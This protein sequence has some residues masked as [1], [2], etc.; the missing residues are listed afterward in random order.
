MQEKSRQMKL[1]RVSMKNPSEVGRR[2]HAAIIEK[3]ANR[4]LS[5]FTDSANSLKSL[6]SR[7]DYLTELSERIL[8][9]MGGVKMKKDEFVRGVASP[10]TVPDTGIRSVRQSKSSQNTKMHGWTFQFQQNLARPMD[11]SHQVRL[12]E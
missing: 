2:G 3:L 6:D 4:A 1:A 11:D 9:T 8:Q 12:S 7:M 10:S 5:T